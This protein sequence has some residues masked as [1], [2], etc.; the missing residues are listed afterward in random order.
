MPNQFTEFIKRIL[1]FGNIYYKKS[2]NTVISDF[3]ACVTFYIAIRISPISRLL[4][5]DVLI[6]NFQ[7][8]NSN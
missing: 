5:S 3:T 6:A 4:V 2:G 1:L 8:N 7:L